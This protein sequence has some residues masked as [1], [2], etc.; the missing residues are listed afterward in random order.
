MVYVV[1]LTHGEVAGSMRVPLGT[2]KAWIRRALIS[3]RECMS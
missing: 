2:A 1:G 3:M